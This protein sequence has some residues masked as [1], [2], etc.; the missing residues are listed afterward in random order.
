MDIPSPHEVHEMLN[1]N[2]VTFA[3]I[4]CN[5]C[6]EQLP[7]F[8]SNHSCAPY[9]KDLITELE[10]RVRQLEDKLYDVQSQMWLMQDD[11]C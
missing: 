5:I 8:Q 7:P 11:N 4:H 10:S 1:A 2:N 9:L 6:N 3:P